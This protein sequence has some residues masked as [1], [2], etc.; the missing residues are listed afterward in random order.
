M[1]GTDRRIRHR[2]RCFLHERRRQRTTVKA[3]GRGR[4]A[5]DDPVDESTSIGVVHDQRQLGRSLRYVAPFQRD[6]LVATVAAV[7]DGNRATFG[8]CWTCQ[9]ESHGRGPPFSRRRR[10]RVRRRAVCTARR[11]RRRRNERCCAEQNQPDR[12]SHN[13]RPGRPPL[14]FQRFD[15]R[16]QLR[17]ESGEEVGATLK[18]FLVERDIQF[19]Q[20]T[21]PGCCPKRHDLVLERDDPAVRDTRARAADGSRVAHRQRGHE[22]G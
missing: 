5:H 22:G 14:R 1:V 10:G 16:F 4:N 11:Q 7:L 19:A 20:M 18:A 6:R 21:R 12:H 13:D 3:A 17:I 9:R 15:D 8:E 2:I